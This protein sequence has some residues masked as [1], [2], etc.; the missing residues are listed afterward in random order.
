MSTLVFAIC[1]IAFSVAAQLSFKAGMSVPAVKS[2]LAGSIT[3][4]SLVVVFTDVRVLGGFLLYAVGAIMWLAVLSKW[5]VSK[6]YPMVG[7]GFILTLGIGALIGEEVTLVRMVG[8]A[9][10]VAGVFFVARS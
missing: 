9:L 8:V 7:L 10:I 2:I 4:R 3:A 1:S 6:A 5:D